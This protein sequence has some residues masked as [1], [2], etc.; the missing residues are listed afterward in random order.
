MYLLPFSND[1]RDHDF[2]LIVNTIKKYFP[3]EKPRRLTSK[4]VPS[5]SGFKKIGKMMDEEF[6]NQNA[7][8]AKWGELTSHL[9]K[10]FEREAD[11]YPDML[12]GGFLGT[13]IFEE[14]KS[15]IFC[16]AKNSQILCKHPW[17]IFFDSRS[18]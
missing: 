10:V 7:Y 15:Q 3:I 2:T 12:G 4:A 16:S 14:G 9:K 13:V 8:R 5:F 11:G 6:L 1:Y 17:T 18:R